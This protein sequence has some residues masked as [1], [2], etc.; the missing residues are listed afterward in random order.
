MRK[1]VTIEKIEELTPIEGADNIE[2]ARIKDWY[3]VVKKG[4]FKE[5]DACV[6]HEIDCFLPIIEPYEFLRKGSKPKKMLVDGKE[7]EG[8]KLKTVKL[9]GVISQGLALPLKVLTNY[10]I[11]PLSQ[12]DIGDNVTE[13]LGILKY[14]QP[15]PA[16]LTGTMKGFFPSFLPKTD[17]E[18]V[19]NIGEAIERNQEKL[20]YIS[21]K[22]DGCSFT[23]Y[24]Y[25]GEFGVCSRNIEL[26]ETK[27]NTHWKIARKY[28]LIDIIS[29][30]IAIQGEVVGSGIQGNPYK[31]NDQKLYIFNIFDIKEQKYFDFYELLTFCKDNNLTTV[32]IINSEFALN[33]SVENLL[34][35]ANGKSVL[36]SDVIREGLVFRPLNEEIEEVNGVRQRF[37]FKVI[38]NEYLL[39]R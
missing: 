25:N 15:I 10:S 9:R 6:Y 36:N 32:P 5:G 28:N 19:Q 30:G 7:V 35:I 22:L 8:F 33:N 37:S 11:I 23:A 4:E 34:D 17:E 27:D 21:E 16:S 39:N 29:E 14:E 13:A 20:F 26:L 31:L 2:K 38:S 12:T 18:R 3:C 1:L 24:Q